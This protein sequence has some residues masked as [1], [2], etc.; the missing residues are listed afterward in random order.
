MTP[1]LFSTEDFSPAQQFDA[2]REWFSPVLDIRRPPTAH[3]EF[4]ATN[5]VWNLGGLVV[6]SVS[7]PPVVVT[8]GRGNI[9]RDPVDHWVISFCKHGETTI[10]TNDALLKASRGVPYVWS[11]GDNSESE[12]SHTERIQIHV[13]RDM[14]KGIAPVL[15]AARG[16]TISSS[17]G[18][19]LGEYMLALEGWLPSVSPVDLPCFENAVCGMIAACLAPSAD[20]MAEASR[21]INGFRAERVRQIV[22]KNLKSPS[23]GPEMIC[24][25]A[26]LSRSSLYRLFEASGG[27]VHYI[28][29]QRLLHAY[30]LLS[31]PENQ[32]SI[33]AISDE[34]CF[35]DASSFSRAFKHEFGCSPRDVRFA[36][37][38]SRPSLEERPRQL[39]PNLTCFADYL[40][41]S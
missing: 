40:H 10:Q 14:F 19:I 29:C 39:L 41:H 4:R 2:W 23:L 6:S 1:T 36:A 20:R 16:M 8:R 24:K 13:P 28:Q 38:H 26:G 5:R 25:E 3:G 35:A 31:D 21:G 33:V 30:N 11:L 7:A 22:R 27:I 34:L 32:A 15:D 12:R 18:G 9:A 37:L 17:L